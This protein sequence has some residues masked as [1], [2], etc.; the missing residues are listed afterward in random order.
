MA[1]DDFKRTLESVH[2]AIAIADA[3]GA[4]VFVNPA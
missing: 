4:I 1:F 2:L 3:K